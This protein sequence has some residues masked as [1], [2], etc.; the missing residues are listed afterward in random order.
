MSVTCFGESDESLFSPVGPPR[1]LGLDVFNIFLNS[2]ANNQKSMIKSDTTTM[3]KYATLIELK[4]NPTAIHCNTRVYHDGYL[5][6]WR[7][8]A[9]SRADYDPASTFTYSLTVYLLVKF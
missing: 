1:I 9:A 4:K 7:V 8:I 2:H 5:T 6:G 3:I